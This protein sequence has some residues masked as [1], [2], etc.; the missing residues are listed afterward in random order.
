MGHS[1]YPNE[2][3]IKVL[4]P[5]RVWPANDSP[6]PDLRSEHRS[7]PVPPE[8]NGFVADTD[9]AFEQKIPDLTE[10]KRIPDVHHHREADDLG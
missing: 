10:R 7:E 9:A 8:P 1:I 2:H 3:F 5:I 4:T 6:F